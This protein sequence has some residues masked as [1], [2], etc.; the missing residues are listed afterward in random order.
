M[1]LME[2]PLDPAS[3]GFRNLE[4]GLQCEVWPKILGCHAHFRH[5]NAFMTHVIIVVAS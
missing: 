1:E 2:P 5:V 3:G 4:R